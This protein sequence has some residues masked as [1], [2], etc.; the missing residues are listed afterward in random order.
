MTTQE[1]FLEAARRMKEPLHLVTAL[2][3][4]VGLGVGGYG[5][6][7]GDRLSACLGLFI[8]SGALCA[9]AIFHSIS[10]LSLRLTTLG[11]GIDELR[12][13]IRRLERSK[14][15]ATPPI[16]PS[17]TVDASLKIIDLPAP[18]KMDASTLA[19]AD[20]RRSRFPRLVADYDEEPQGREAR[21][22]GHEIETPPEPRVSEVAPRSP[23]IEAPIDAQSAARQRWE[24]AR[25]RRD[26]AGARLAVEE[27]SAV[28]SPSDHPALQ[29]AL[30]E[31]TAELLEE[32]RST[33]A[34]RVRGRDFGGAIKIGKQIVEHYPDSP[35]AAEFTQL[36]PILRRRHQVFL[37]AVS[38]TAARME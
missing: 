32:W 7:A 14:P 16:A 18:G 6:V 22:N 20:L 10:R 24:R 30:A 19:G 17:A 25:D 37:D 27:L 15:A 33:F 2:Y 1:R 26:L 38:A 36:E 5:A 9:A 3:V 11:E 13:S 35:T 23:R 8:V 4:I 29:A 21:S 31:F 28:S 34:A 12:E